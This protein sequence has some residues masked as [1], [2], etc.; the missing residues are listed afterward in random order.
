MAKNF[1]RYPQFHNRKQ[2]GDL[3]KR[4]DLLK[5][6]NDSALF[7]FTGCRGGEGVSTI[8]MNLATYLASSEGDSKVL[9]VDA[10]FTNPVLHDALDKDIGNGLSD[11]LKGSSSWSDSVSS[12]NFDNLHFLS[13]GGSYQQL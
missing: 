13:C 11:I 5:Q 4:M 6:K 7:S 10:N 3:H 1:W 8:L 9:L 2:I 12:T